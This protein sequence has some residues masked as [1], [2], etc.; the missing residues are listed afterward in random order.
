MPS[1]VGCHPE[2]MLPR[3]RA[4]A[5][6]DDAPASRLTPTVAEIHVDALRH[7]ARLLQERAAPAPLMGVVKA[8]AYGHGAAGVASILQEE[9]V[10]HFAVA[11]VPEALVLRQT[12]LAAPIL[13]FAA[14][15]PGF[16]AAYVEH[17]LEVTVPSRA[18][19]EAVAMTARTVGPLRVHIKID[20]GMSRLGLPPDEAE[21]I[22]R[23]LEAAPGVT[24]AGLWTHLATASDEADAFALEQLERFEP[25]RQRLGAAFEF[26]HV[27][28]SGGILHVPPSF[29]F[30]RA[31]VRAGIALYGLAPPEGTTGLRPVMRLT[32]RITH[33]KT[34]EAGTSV[35]YGRRWTAPRRTRLATVGAGYADGFP[36]L[37]SNRAEVTIRSRRYPVAGTVC[38]DMFM[39]DLG[40]PGTHNEDIAVGDLV[41]LFGP[42]GPTTFEVARWAETITYEIC[43]GVSARVPRLYMG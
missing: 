28:H 38:M 27:A 2:T 42:G 19:A 23:L 15:L 6:P 21:A 4:D 8:N 1:L 11:T 37:L 16:L 25:L 7:N 40:P 41:V 24:L 20:T 39:V 12:G 13:V 10:R 29:G 32:S 36:R 30:E 34:I 3:N 14:P 5:V 33:L 31:L 26:I 43:C 22:V 18:V 9:G 17:D 35:S